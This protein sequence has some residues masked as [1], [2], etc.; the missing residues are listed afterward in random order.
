MFNSNYDP[1]SDNSMHNSH[2]GASNHYYNMSVF[3]DLT[4]RIKLMAQTIH[5]TFK[6]NG[7]YGNAYI[8]GQDEMKKYAKRQNQII[9]FFA[10]CQI[11]LLCYAYNIFLLIRVRHFYCH[12]SKGCYRND[13]ELAEYII[14]YQLWSSDC[15]DK[16]QLQMNSH[17]IGSTF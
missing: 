12:S 4:M 15:V 2:H 16:Y 10:D 3:M 11:N 9:F 7:W 13:N 5:T 17:F 8:F 6:L 14:W 1:P